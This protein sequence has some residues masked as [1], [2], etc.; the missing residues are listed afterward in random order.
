[1][2]LIFVTANLPHGTDE[3]FI[4][5]EIEQLVRDGHQ[6]LIVPRS[7]KG[8]VIHGQDVLKH[9]RSEALCSA[10]VI[11]KAMRAAS[12]EPARAARALAPVLWSRTLG[13]A[14]KN[15]SIVPKALWLAE[16]AREW[17]AEHLHSHW[18]GTTATLTMVA[19][20]FSGIPWSFTAHR[21]DIVENNLLKEKVRRASLARF[22]S[23]DG[24]RMAR[25]LGIGTTHNA[26][27]LY[28][29]VAFPAEVE[30]RRG[31][32]PIVVCPA[33]L[34]DVKGHRFLLEAWR[35]LRK[36]GVHAEL[37]LAGDGALRPQLE[38]LAHSFGLHHSVKFLGTLKHD[39]LL[40][41]YKEI[42]V[43]AVVLAS[44]DLGRG[45]HEGIPVALMEAMAYGIPVVATSAGGTPELVRPGTGLLVPPA[46]P[47]ALADAFQKLLQDRI[48][49]REIGDRG[50]QHVRETHD[51]V[52]VAAELASAL[53]G[54]PATHQHN[55]SVAA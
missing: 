2:K 37:W 42:P 8:L 43:S 25:M 39:E 51:I 34:V 46:D 48:L 35:I 55:A 11:K 13:I 32:W 21:W 38:S 9:T 1:M 6:V 23:E 19:S 24:L 31:E 7:P 17:G 26:R 36:R 30:R 29:G 5:P 4:V 12:L 14:A 3:A 20:S 40:E 22:I 16:I 18:A 49:L 33:R 47:L 53:E 10:T 15:L 54:R 27:V 45:V 50:R 44:T 41:I 28:M 52:R